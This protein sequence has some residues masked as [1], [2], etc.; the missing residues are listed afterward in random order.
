MSEDYSEYHVFDIRCKDVLE[1]EGV[2]YAGLLNEHGTIIAGGFKDGIVKLEKDQAKFKNFIDRVIEI[3]L[4]TEHEE[5]LGKLNYI[6]CRRDKIILLSFPFPVSRNVLLISA[7]P[8]VNIE[9]LAKRVAQIFGDSNLFSAWDM[10]NS[11]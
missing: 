2:R 7:E 6:S 11:N 4:R 10:K 9:K 3:S 8:T 1:E 5:T